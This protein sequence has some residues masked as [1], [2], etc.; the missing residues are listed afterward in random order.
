[1]HGEKKTNPISLIASK[2]SWQ[3][4]GKISQKNSGFCLEGQVIQQGSRKLT[5][6]PGAQGLEGNTYHTQC[7]S[8]SHSINSSASII[9]SE[10]GALSAESPLEG[11][12][13][14]FFTRIICSDS[15]NLILQHSCITRSL[16]TFR[17]PCYLAWDTRYFASYH[18][19]L[20]SKKRQ[21][22]GRSGA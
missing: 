12:S 5:S 15:S 14:L 10:K 19:D 3:K 8:C 16:F 13:W 6:W 22:T 2:C 20:L 7:S 18:S 17:A 4:S 9:I 11:G 21:Q 1:M